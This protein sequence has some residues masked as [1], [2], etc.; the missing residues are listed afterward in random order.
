MDAA[1]TARDSCRQVIQAIEALAGAGPNL[2]YD[3]AQTT[4]SSGAEPLEH[5]PAGFAW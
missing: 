3:P 5:C 1:V 2:G 4:R